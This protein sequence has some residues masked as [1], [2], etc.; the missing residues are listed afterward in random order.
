MFSKILTSTCLF[1]VA[2]NVNAASADSCQVSII[3]PFLAKPKNQALSKLNP[4]AIQLEAGSFESVLGPLPTAT[5]SDGVTLRRNNQ[6]MGAGGAKYDPSRKALIL[7]GDVYYDDSNTQINSDNAEF[8]YGDGQIKFEGA[9]FYVN[10]SNGHG[11]ADVL[12]I[13]RNSRL[14]LKNVEYTTCPIGSEDWLIQGKSIVLDTKKG[15]STVKG[16][17]LRFKGLPIL[18]TPYLSFPMSNA[19]KS[20]LLT[21]EIGSS[22]RSGNEIRL[23]WYLN[24]APNYD[25]TIT[26]RLLSNRGVQIAAEFRYLTKRNKGSIS[27]DYLPDDSIINLARHQFKLQHQ[28]LFNNGWRNQIQLSEVSDNQYYEDLGGTLSISSITH[29]NRSIRFDYNSPNFSILG[30][31]QDYQTIDNVILEDQKPYRRL[32]QIL[33]NG[34]WGI[35]FGFRFGFDGEVVNFDRNIG[36]TG[37]RFNATPKLEMPITRPGWFLNPSIELNHTFYELKNT[38]P[39]KQSR[40]SR[41]VPIASFDAGIFLERS[42][43]NSNR[44]QTIEPRLLYAYIPER[45]QSDIPI[46]DTIIPDFNLVQLFRKNRYLGIDR[47]GDTNHVSVGITTRILNLS[48]GQELMSATIGQTQYLSDRFVRLPNQTISSNKTSDYVAQLRILLFKN[49]NFD[50]GHQWG[51]GSEDT[52]RSEARLQYKPAN[53]KVLNIAYR[54]R[55]KSLEQA[56]LSWSWPIANRW[57]FVGRYNFSLRDKEVLEQFFGLEYESCCWG[58]RVISRRH[59]STRNGA[60]DSSFGL[61]LVLKGM[62]SVGTAADKLLERGILGYSPDIR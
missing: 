40:L 27:A 2:I 29:L 13:N 11:A 28:T 38:L 50:F 61:Q 20:G 55:K 30:Q 56:D 48:S 10:A 54:F 42:M 1:L 7:K 25:A 15:V 60:H 23:P 45:D 51:A 16:M 46:F 53:N 6:F 59:L 58:L 52:T 44:I 34:S 49:I 18:Y 5:M 39:N 37:W 35:P 31:I 9:R 32:P 33:I 41:I 22:G 57:N 43:K 21:P 17:K 24:I 62:T 14:E 12:E 3:K 47:I 26:P 19:R 8:S 36:I 4:E